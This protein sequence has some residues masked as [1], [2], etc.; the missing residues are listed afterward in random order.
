MSKRFLTINAAAPEMNYLSAALA[1]QNMLEN[2]VRPYTNKERWWENS[3]ATTPHLKKF[4]KHTF[5]KRMMPIGLPNEKIIEAGIGLDFAFQLAGKLKFPQLASRLRYALQ[6]KVSRKAESLLSSNSSIVGQYIVSLPAFKACQGYKI[7]NYS[8]AHH[9]YI[10]KFYAEESERVPLFASTLPDWSRQPSWLI[11]HLDEEIA[12]ADY[13]L[14][15]STFACESFISEGIP[16]QKI[17]TIPYGIDVSQ[18]SLKTYR[19]PPLPVFNVLFVGQL[20]QRKGIA[21]LLEAYKKF[22]GTG[23]TLTLTGSYVGSPTAFTPYHGMYKHVP[24][25][26][27]AELPSIYHQAD[28]FV[29]PTLLEGMGLVVLE[30]MAC[31]LPVITTPNGPGDLVRDGIDGFIVPPRDVDAIVEKLEYFRANP[32]QCEIMGRNA[33]ERALTFTWSAYQEKILN[34]LR[35]LP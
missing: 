32:E 31:G 10:V 24:H 18:F 4:Y 33:R 34:F 35:E 16:G 30:A 12:L 13:V 1:E 14:V 7:L 3:I 23:T 25:V 8:I 17:I 26:P 6:K 2:Y 21:Y 20:S 28:V 15:G 11:P 19:K 27:R 29:F 22:Q 5:G 9:D